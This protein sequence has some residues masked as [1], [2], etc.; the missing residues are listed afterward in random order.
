[1]FASRRP[2]V[3][4]N[5]FVPMSAKIADINESDTDIHFI[6]FADMGLP[7]NVVQITLTATRVSGT[8]RLQI[9]PSNGLINIQL[10]LNSTETETFHVDLNH[11]KYKQTVANDD[12]DL[13][14]LGYVTQRSRG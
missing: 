11:I 5:E 4:K 6:A 14:C 3:K 8:G 10:S 2:I 13:I 12:F 9:Y 1:M 7:A